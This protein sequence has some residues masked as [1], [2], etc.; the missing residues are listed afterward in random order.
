MA[1]HTFET[2]LQSHLA[3]RPRHERLVIDREEPCATAR[4]AGEIARYQLLLDLRHA[5]DAYEQ[6]ILPIV[7]EERLWRYQLDARSAR[8]TVKTDR[9]A[10]EGLSEKIRLGDGRHRNVYDRVILHAKAGAVIS[11]PTEPA[12]DLS[13]GSGRRSRQLRDTVALVHRLDRP[14]T[15]D[16]AGSHE[17]DLFGVGVREID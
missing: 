1:R 4:R 10:A 11:G 7:D 12:A 15:G 14:I 5:V 16:A 17:S 6:T 13:D 2:M 9:A 3:H 8:F